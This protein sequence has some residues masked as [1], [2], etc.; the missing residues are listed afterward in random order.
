MSATLISLIGMFLALLGGGLMYTF[1]PLDEGD[2]TAMGVEDA[3][4]VD[5]GRRAGDVR[6]E[7]AVRS[8]RN[9]RLTKFGFALVAVG[10]FVQ[11]YAT[12]AG[13]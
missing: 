4:I 10:T 3:N 8:V 11:M 13:Q 12:S 2:P 7:R 5:G 1:P 6:A 9:A